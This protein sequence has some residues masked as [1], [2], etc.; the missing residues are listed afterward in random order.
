MICS[1]QFGGGISTNRSE[2]T[3]YFRDFDPLVGR[4]VQPDAIGL[5]GGLTLYGYANNDPLQFADPL[6]LL[7]VCIGTWLDQ[8]WGRTTRADSP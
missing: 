4:Y 5:D 2:L 8:G 7:S 1:S 6:G 3:Y